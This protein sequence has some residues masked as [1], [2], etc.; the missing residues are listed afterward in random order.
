MFFFKHRPPACY[1]NTHKA[2]YNTENVSIFMCRL[3]SEQDT[4]LSINRFFVSG[5]GI[6]DIDG[7]NAQIFCTYFW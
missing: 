3:I 6:K 2:L 4:Y 1:N 7:L 5:F